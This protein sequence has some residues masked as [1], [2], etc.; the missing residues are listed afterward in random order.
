MRLRIQN[1]CY[2]QKTFED[3]KSENA[4]IETQSRDRRK[5]KFEN[6]CTATKARKKQ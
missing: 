3:L 4:K 5:R 2:L 6:R 1:Q